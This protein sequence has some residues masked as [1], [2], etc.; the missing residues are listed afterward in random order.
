LLI[1]VFALESPGRSR[2]AMIGGETAD[3]S[4]AVDEN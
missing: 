3:A 1:L 4:V 2:G